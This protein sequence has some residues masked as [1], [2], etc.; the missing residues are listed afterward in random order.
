MKNNIP[1][2]VLVRPYAHSLDATREM[3][4][5]AADKMTANTRDRDNAGI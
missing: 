2:G 4:C 5:A 3:R 1:C